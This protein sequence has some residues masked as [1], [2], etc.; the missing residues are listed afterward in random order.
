MCVCCVLTSDAV[1]QT[2]PLRRTPASSSLACDCT[3]K[4]AKV[5]VQIVLLCKNAAERE[6]HFSNASVLCKLTHRFVLAAGV[7][8]QALLSGIVG[9][10]RIACIAGRDVRV[11]SVYAMLH[12]GLLVGELNIC[13][14]L[15][16]FVRNSRSYV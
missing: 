12:I 13:E 1:L 14:L 15:I 6:W 2:L 11:C 10:M 9:E 7:A 16:L 3:I 8:H 4:A 5:K